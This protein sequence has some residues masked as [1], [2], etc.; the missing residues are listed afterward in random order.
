MFPYGPDA[1]TLHLWHLDEAA[2]R[3]SCTN[4]VAGAV[5][6]TAIANGASLG[7]P[8]L[9]GFGSSLSTY[10]GG[11]AATDDAGKNACLSALPLV[12]GSADN[13]ALALA[14]PATGVFTVEALIR[15]DFN[16]SLNYGSVASGGNGRAAPMMIISGEDEANSGRVFQFRIDPIGILSPANSDV[17]LK[18]IHLNSGGTTQNRSFRVPTTGPDAIAS[19]KWYHVAVSYNG[20]EGTADSLKFYWTLADPS[21]TNASLIGSTNLLADLPVASTDFCIGN[22]GRTTPNVNFVGLID[23]VR[24]SSVARRANEFIFDTDT[25]ADGLPDRWENAYFPSIATSGPADDPDEDL[26]TN[27]QEYRGGSNPA[28]AA[29]TP[30]DKDADGLPDAWENLHFGFLGY[31]LSDDP[32]GDTY[33]NLEEYLAGTDPNNAA[34]N[35]ADGDRDGLPDAWELACFGSLAY[36]AYDDFDLDGY[37]N[38]REY[39]AGTAPNNPESMPPGPAVKLVPV[40]DDNPATPEYGN[41][42]AE[43]MNSSSFERSGLITFGTQQFIAYYGRH[44]TDSNYALNDRVFVGRRS[45]GASRWDVFRTDY[46]SYSINDGHNII[47]GGIDGGGFLHLSWGMHGNSLKYARTVAP[48]TGS[49]AIRFPTNSSGQTIQITMGSLVGPTNQVTYPHFIP[50]PGGDLLFLYRDGVS[51]GGDWYLNRYRTASQTWVSVNTNATGQPV[52]FIGGAS[53][54]PNYNAYVDQPRIDRFGRFHLTWV[55][56]YNGDSPAGESGYQT[57][58]D[59]NYVYSDDFGVTWHR[60]DGSPITLPI[61]E[62]GEDQAASSQWSDVVYPIPEG[63]SL[64]NQAGLCVDSQGTPYI[65]NWW[66]PGAHSTPPNHIRQYL[67]LFPSTNGWVS[68][69]ISHRVLDDP[70]YKRPEGTLRDMRRPVIVCDPQDR[71]IVL[72]RDA[73]GNRGIRAVYTPPKT[74]DPLRLNWTE[75]DLTTENLGVTDPMIDEDLWEKAHILHIFHQ[76]TESL[77][78]DFNVPLPPNTAS[79]VAVLEWDTIAY[80]AHR[81]ALRV[82]ASYPNTTLSWRSQLGWSYRLLTTTNLSNSSLVTMLPGNGDSLS[83]VHTNSLI[84]SQRFWQLELKQGGF[85]P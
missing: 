70:N 6:L 22:T 23:E 10:D 46:V 32:D 9:P 35:P 65:A 72:Y 75:V 18:F 33:T 82:A 39:Q 30:A 27:L 19:N 73:E 44:P 63:S 25:D 2:G 29:S 42:N 51:G 16:P 13:V 81:P 67:V 85:S 21:R 49:Q 45:H 68:R 34:S 66:A 59:Y 4:A 71:L 77:P 60:Y 41:A 20:L 58:H 38:L 1:T 3:T 61:V 47:S 74:A 28:S 56:R 64:M 40:D 48:V 5:T 43:R 69:Q 55:W 17:L 53:F 80:F 15:L 57:N 50:L 8:A 79:P 7:S 24:I 14:H 78:A 37:S 83:F 52:P 62:K 11:P 12:N 36:G 26:V 31:G 84:G 54:T 76:V